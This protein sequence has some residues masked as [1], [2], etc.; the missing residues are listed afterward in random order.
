M[1]GLSVSRAELVVVRLS[2]REVE[3]VVVWM[4]LLSS[5][6][7]KMKKKMKMLSP[8]TVSAERTFLQRLGR[9]YGTVHTVHNTYTGSD[10]LVSHCA[11]K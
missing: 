8:E 2:D 11:V 10:Q 9:T 3:V 1:A 5:K 6:K 7:K 4:L